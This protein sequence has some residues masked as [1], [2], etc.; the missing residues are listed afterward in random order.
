MSIRRYKAN[1][2]HKLDGLQHDQGYRGAYGPG[3]DSSVNTFFEIH[4]CSPRHKCQGFLVI[5]KVLQTNLIVHDC[6][7][8]FD[9]LQLNPVPLGVTEPL[10]IS[11]ILGNPLPTF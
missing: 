1:S 2:G 10:K 3:Y 4:N 8:T 5:K 9:T 11:K 7:K 6:F